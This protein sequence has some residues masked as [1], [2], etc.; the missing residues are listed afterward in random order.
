MNYVRKPRGREDEDESIRI[1]KRRERG[2]FACSFKLYM[3]LLFLRNSDVL[4][5]LEFIETIH[6]V[7]NNIRS[8]QPSTITAY[9]EFSSSL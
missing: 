1:C 4:T 2:L 3:H 6:V 7:I 9:N 8:S 5:Q